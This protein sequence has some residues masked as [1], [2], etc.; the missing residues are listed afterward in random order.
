[1]GKDAKKL[2]GLASAADLARVE[3]KLDRIAALLAQEVVETPRGKKLKTKR[4]LESTPQ[5]AHRAHVGRSAAARGWTFNGWT[6]RFGLR[7]YRMLDAAEQ[8]EADAG[9]SGS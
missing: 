3:A 2:E 6:E 5:T 1:M 7:T 4:P 9:P 8:A